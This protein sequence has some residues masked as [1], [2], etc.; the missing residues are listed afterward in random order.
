MSLIDFEDRDFEDSEEASFRIFQN[1]E[2]DLDMIVT[3]DMFDNDNEETENENIAKEQTTEA[4]KGQKKKKKKQYRDLEYK[5]LLTN[6]RERI[7]QR[8]LNSAFRI[9]RKTIPAYPHD[10]KLS[11]Y[12]VL[13]SAIRYLVFL[14]D[15]L[16]DME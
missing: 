4:R 14:Q 3:R 15:L 10:A 8:T 9:L 5:R 2:Q 6:T 16:T 12:S 13:K 7:R 1:D 11:K